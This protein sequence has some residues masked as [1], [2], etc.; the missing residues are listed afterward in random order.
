MAKGY[1]ED[2]QIQRSSAELLEKELG[3]TSVYAFLPKL[4]IACFPS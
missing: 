1:S 3:W 4:A 2:Q